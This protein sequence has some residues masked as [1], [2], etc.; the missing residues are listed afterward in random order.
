MFALLLLKMDFD[1]SQ[2]QDR[3][4]WITRIVPAE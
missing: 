3:R 4:I 2:G 1:W